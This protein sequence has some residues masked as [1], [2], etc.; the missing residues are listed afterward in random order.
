LGVFCQPEFQIFANLDCGGIKHHFINPHTQH[1]LFGQC[2]RFEH[3]LRASRLHE[4][5]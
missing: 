3:S 1:E 4:L 2:R 5:A